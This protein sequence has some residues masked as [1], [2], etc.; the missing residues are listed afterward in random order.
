MNIYFSNFTGDVAFRILE[1]IN[2][3]GR[4]AM[5]DIH[6]DNLLEETQ[7]FV[8]DINP[9]ML[10]VGKKRAQERGKAILY[11]LYS[12]Y[13]KWNLISLVIFSKYEVYSFFNGVTHSGFGEDKSL[14]WVEGDAE[15]LKFEDDLMDGYTIAFGI[16]NVTHIEKALAEAYR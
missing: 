9:N 11:F 2:N 10:S 15:Q 13:R 5:R 7:I 12:T 8:C 3:V 16:R 6:D 1:S 14:I 4:R